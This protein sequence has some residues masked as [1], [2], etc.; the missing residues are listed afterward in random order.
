[1]KAE[2]DGEDECLISSFILP[3]SSFNEKSPEAAGASGLA[4]FG[5]LPLAALNPGGFQ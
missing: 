3:H 1:M 2:K 4:Y 5:A